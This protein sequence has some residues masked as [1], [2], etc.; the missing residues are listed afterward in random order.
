MEQ[1][2]LLLT[3]LLACITAYLAYRYGRSV[4]LWY[5]VGIISFP[6]SILLLLILG[7]TELKK[8]QDKQTQEAK[9]IFEKMFKGNF[10]NYK[11]K[12]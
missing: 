12:T 3:P 10:D 5:M 6:L 4:L 1:N 11:E 8:Q 9:K 2:I 7:K